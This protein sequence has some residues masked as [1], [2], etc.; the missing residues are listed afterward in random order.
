MLDRLRTRAHDLLE[1][2][3]GDA[4]APV[5]VFKRA[6]RRANE[7]IG[8][9]IMSAEE[10]AERRQYEQGARVAEPDGARA[11]PEVGGA[12]P[13]MIFHLDKHHQKVRRM[14][15][16]LESAGIGH[17]VRNI[18]GDMPAIEATE[19][20]SGGFPMPVVFIGASCVGG[21]T[22]LI[23]LQGNG[24]L[25]PLVYSGREIASPTSKR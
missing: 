7:A 6:A 9:P 2:G 24:E 13:V 8:S 17:E 12:A 10:L 20:D 4:I 14:R 16:L 15:E 1:S 5:R 19:R 21:L 25:E 3:R 22:E 11:E 23:N 18:E